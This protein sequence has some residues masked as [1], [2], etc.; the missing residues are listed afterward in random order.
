MGR[1]AINALFVS[2]D[3]AGVDLDLVLQSSTAR[4]LGM[5]SMRE[6]AELTSGTFSIESAP[7]EGTTIRVYWLVEAEG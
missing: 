3:G 2:D 1:T 6:R 5:T 7:G 4:S